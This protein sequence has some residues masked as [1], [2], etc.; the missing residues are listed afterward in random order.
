[1]WAV[2]VL[3]AFG[4]RRRARLSP[5]WAFHA[6]HRPCPSCAP[7]CRVCTIA[8]G[9]AAA[10]SRTKE[11]PLPT[12]L[13]KP[14]RSFLI[15]IGSVMGGSAPWAR[16]YRTLDF[17]ALVAG[18][19][20][21][22]SLTAPSHS[23]Q[24]STPAMTSSIPAIDNLNAAFQRAFAIRPKV[25]GFPVLAEVLRQAGVTRNLWKL[26]SAQSVYLTD[27]GPV[28]N[29]GTPLV[30][31]MHP[32]PA[33]D[34]AAVVRAIRADQAG[35][36]TFPEFLHG[37]WN[38]GIVHY[39]VDFAARVVTYNGVKGERYIEAYPAVNL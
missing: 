2:N 17:V 14:R 35:E 4:S 25:G 3:P 30:A 21:A 19:G 34:E 26:P 37:V 33:F 31:G 28:V 8:R 22:A 20:R 12:T 23:N 16:V 32:I 36:T 7:R 5:A 10:C 13:R 29:Q 9:Q 24:E 6:L 1:M 38:A 39:D 18:C 11:A 27:L 15:S